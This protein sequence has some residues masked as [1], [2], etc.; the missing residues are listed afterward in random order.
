M[1]HIVADDDVLPNLPQVCTS[2]GNV[3]DGS[4]GALILKGDLSKKQTA[5][6]LGED[7]QGTLFRTSLAQTCISHVYIVNFDKAFSFSSIQVFINR[8]FNVSASHCKIIIH[9]ES[10]TQNAGELITWTDC[11][12]HNSD[13]FYKVTVK[14]SMSLKGVLWTII[15][16]VYNLIITKLLL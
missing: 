13:Y 3:L 10:N 7:A 5:I 4:S 11:S 2:Q 6:R 12:F 9:D 15:K 14:H 16:K 1:F 8:F